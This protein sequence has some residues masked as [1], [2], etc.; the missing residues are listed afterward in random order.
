MRI[1][2]QTSSPNC[3]HWRLSSGSALA[4]VRLGNNAGVSLVG[5]L[6]FVCP[7]SP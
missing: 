4:S 3:W 2:L 6:S 5:A 7:E 1:A